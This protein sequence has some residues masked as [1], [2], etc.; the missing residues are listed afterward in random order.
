VYER[1]EQKEKS[2]G[3][4]QMLYKRM[5]PLMEENRMTFPLVLPA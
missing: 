5:V 3:T 1:T 2:R 4:N